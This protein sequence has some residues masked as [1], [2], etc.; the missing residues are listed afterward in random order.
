MSNINEE[1]D[2]GC[3]KFDKVVLSFRINRDLRDR[4]H[5]IARSESR[6]LANWY[7]LILTREVQKREGKE[8]SLEDKLDYICDKLDLIREHTKNIKPA[9]KSSEKKESNGGREL[10]Q[11]FELDLPDTLSEEVWKRWVIYQ[12]CKGNYLKL[13]LANGLLERW[14]EDS[15]EYDLDLD[16]LVNKAMQNGWKDIVIDKT[17]KKASLPYWHGAK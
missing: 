16:Y 8:S 2:V 14:T 6:T 9:S 10:Q 17:V 7:E 15:N 11:I 4:A 13:D 3:D 5:K 12:R 1:L